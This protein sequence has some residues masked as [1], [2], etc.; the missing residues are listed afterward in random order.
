MYMMYMIVCYNALETGRSGIVY[1]EARSKF[2]TV[3]I[4]TVGGPAQ[5]ELSFGGGSSSVACTVGGT[6]FR[7]TIHNHRLKHPDF[8][9]YLSQLTVYYV[10]NDICSGPCSPSAL[11]A[12]SLAAFEAGWHSSHVAGVKMLILLLYSY[13]LLLV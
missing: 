5:G 4:R 2:S 6:F 13:I 1:A 3:E 10:S 9:G 11:L 12:Y 8:E 7:E